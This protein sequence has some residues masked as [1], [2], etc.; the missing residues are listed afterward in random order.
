MASLQD[1]LVDEQALGRG[2][3]GQQAKKK[4]RKDECDHHIENLD[5][6]WETVKVSAT[7]CQLVQFTKSKEGLK[8]EQERLQDELEALDDEEKMHP[9]VERMKE[10]QDFLAR[11]G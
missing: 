3:Q 9:I 4:Q 5:N 8:K 11:R 2:N 1:E 7:Y 10:I 6:N